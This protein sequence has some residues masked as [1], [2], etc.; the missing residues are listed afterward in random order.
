MIT[1]ETFCG[2]SED[3]PL[4]LGVDK[5]LSTPNFKGSSS[6]APQNVSTVIIGNLS[7]SLCVKAAW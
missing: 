1:V 3:D 5:A 2:A 6:D 4:K 7:L